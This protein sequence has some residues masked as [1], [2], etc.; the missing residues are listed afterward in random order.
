[1]KPLPVS[2]LLALNRILE[3]FST[4]AEWLKCEALSEASPPFL[5]DHLRTTSLA[6]LTDF[7]RDCVDLELSTCL[8]TIHRIQDFLSKPKCETKKFNELCNE[9]GGRLRDE[10]F[11]KECFLLTLVE[12]RYYR[13]PM[14]GWEEIVGRFKETLADIEESGKCFAFERYAAAIYHSLQVVEVGLIELGTFIGVKDPKS[15]WTAVA[16]ELEKIV[17]KKR[18]LTEFE[19]KNYPFL[20]QVQGT[21]AA[22]K[23]AWRNKIGHAQG[24]LLLLNKDFSPEIAEEILLATRAFMRRLATDLPAKT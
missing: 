22:L 7:E 10:T 14:K 8:V 15:G 4:D 2:K 3:R 6:A 9:L 16:N 23:N 13:Q 19:E 1:M 24:S 20:E 21:V 5:S 18:P 11:A 12:A 17:S